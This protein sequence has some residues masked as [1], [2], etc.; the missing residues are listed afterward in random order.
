[1]LCRFP[2][3]SILP[4][5]LGGVALLSVSGVSAQ[6]D[7]NIERAPSGELVLSW[8]QAERNWVLQ[9]NLSL[10]DPRQ[11]NTRL[12]SPVLNGAQ[13]EQVYDL[14]GLADSR[15]YR[16]KAQKTTGVAGGINFLRDSQNPATG[17]WELNGQ[18]SSFRD[19][20]DIL[21]VLVDKGG[22]ADLIEGGTF[23]LGFS[24][25]RNHDDLA[26]KTRALAMQGL[27]YTALR[28]E[29]LEGE[30]A[31]I[32]DPVSDDYPGGGWGLAPGFGNSVIDS[33]LCL[34]ALKA[35]DTPTGLSAPNQALG[36]NASSPSYTFEMPAGAT[37]VILFVRE[38]SGNCGFTI[39]PPSGAGSGFAV[40]PAVTPAPIIWGTGQEGTWTVDVT[41]L[42]A[43][44]VSYTF[45]VLFTTAD[46]IEVGNITAGTTYLVWSQNVDG[47]WGLRQ[48]QDSHFLATCEAMKTLAL[49]G[50]AM[51]PFIDAGA[52]WL[53][54]KQNADGGFS[55]TA[56]NSNVMETGMAIRCLELATTPPNL[57]T[58]RT[59]LGNQQRLNGSWGDDPYLTAL[60]V[61]ALG[62]PPVVSSIPDQTVIAPTDF[63]TINLDAFVTDAF[64]P[65]AD[66]VWS[67]SGNELLD[68][69]IVDRVVTI[70]YPIAF[71]VSEE[72]S[73]TATNSE[74]LTD[75]VKAS[76]TVVEPATAVPDHTVSQ[77]ASVT[78]FNAVTGTEE[79]VGAVAL[80]SGP[81]ITGLPAGMSY[82]T[83]GFSFV[84]TIEFNTNFQISAGAATPV[85]TY[86]IEVAY[87]F[88]DSDSLAIPNLNNT[89]FNLVVEVTP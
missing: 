78:G 2:Q 27:E 34:R 4:V 85:G 7:L 59:W 5:L 18:P 36:A 37:E 16:L 77:G 10:I 53:E 72:I 73:F 58:A 50:P 24:E 83:T 57:D 39:T 20:S 80:F 75:S 43:S 70:S 23:A 26:R 38:V 32:S 22:P 56:D 48:S 89:T 40:S 62:V 21:Q 45:E 79:A 55:T 67:V 19:T 30:N 8:D 74:L 44:P 11:W 6:V 15:F 35:T 17:L 25:T 51:Q 1:M 47:G 81:V 49:C 42:T 64:T 3:T 63:T 9:E 87:T 41:N 84:S 61:D 31:A 54:G 33:A 60:A 86:A 12:Q 52:N 65:D 88:L 13:L 69:S 68:V 71:N 66:I 14:A 82:N 76:F 28:D 29:I 46:G